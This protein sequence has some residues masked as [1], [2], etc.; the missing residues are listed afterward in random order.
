LAFRGFS[1]ARQI[2]S[3]KSHLALDTAGQDAIT[4]LAS[5]GEPSAPAVSQEEAVAVK[6]KC[7]DS[8]VGRAAD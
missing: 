7:P 2:D 6:G 4:P 3:K 5:G 1:T 8:S